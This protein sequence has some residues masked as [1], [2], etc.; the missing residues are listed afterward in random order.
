MCFAVFQQGAVRDV[1]PLCRVHIG[2]RI[3][4]RRHKDSAEHLLRTTAETQQEQEQQPAAAA[5]SPHSAW[6]ESAG[7]SELQCP[8]CQAKFNDRDA[9]EYMNHWEECAK[10]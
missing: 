4:S 9:A 1:I 8:R 6:N 2:H 10:L 5:A 7:L 3:S